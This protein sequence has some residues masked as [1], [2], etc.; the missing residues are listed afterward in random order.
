M[1]TGMDG[2]KNGPPRLMDKWVDEW[3]ESRVGYINVW[4]RDG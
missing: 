2:W 4:G 1:G 3:M